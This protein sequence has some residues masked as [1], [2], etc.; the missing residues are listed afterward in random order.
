MA[1]QQK[2]SYDGECDSRSSAEIKSSKYFYDFQMF[3]EEK[4][5]WFCSQDLVEELSSQN[6]KYEASRNRLFSLV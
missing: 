1:Q 5:I 6:A 3:K 2:N 4:P